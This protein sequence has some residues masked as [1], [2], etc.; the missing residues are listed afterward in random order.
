MIIY[1]ESPKDST[2]TL[3]NLF[4]YFS[5]TVGYKINIQKSV[6]FIFTNNEFSK[7][8]NVISFTTAFRDNKIPKNTFNK[9]G[10]KSVL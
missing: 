5:K 7:K 3:L 10:E 4:S 8:R 6:A 1:T 9:G 2:K